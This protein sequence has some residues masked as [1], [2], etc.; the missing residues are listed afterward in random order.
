MTSVERPTLIELF[1]TFF[2]RMSSN[3]PHRDVMIKELYYFKSHLY[4]NDNQVIRSFLESISSQ[5]KP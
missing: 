5:Y 1:S 4:S 3:H 2:D